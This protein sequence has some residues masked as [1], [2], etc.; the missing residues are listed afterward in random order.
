MDKRIVVAGIGNL[1]LRDEGVGIHV[2]NELKEHS[3]PE[4]VEVHDCA[5]RGIDALN[6]L[7]GADKAIIIDAVK[8]GNEPG[9]VYRFTLDELERNDKTL[10]MISFHDLDLITAIKIGR[11]TY[12]LPKEVVI[13]G[14]EPKCADEYSMELTPEVAKA[15]PKAVKAV[16][17]E[18]KKSE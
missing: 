10:R 2:I 14:I 3:L 4:N 6:E 8:L 18:I 17:D 9:A 13:I 7:E 1:L 11:D 12:N 5:T 16:L 15:V